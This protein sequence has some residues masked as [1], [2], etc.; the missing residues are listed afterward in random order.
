M[1]ACT[2]EQR[3]ERLRHYFENHG[4]VA[5]C[6]QNFGRREASSTPHICFLAKKLKEIGTLIDK[7]KCEKPKTVR[8]PENIVAVLESEV[9]RHQH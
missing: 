2:L 1:V 6:V 5:E 7:P 3:R 4:N 8:A 9:K